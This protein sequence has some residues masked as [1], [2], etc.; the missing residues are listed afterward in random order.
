M[1]KKLI[2]LQVF[3]KIFRPKVASKISFHHV[4]HRSHRQMHIFELILNLP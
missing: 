1:E 2:E 3:L 4:V